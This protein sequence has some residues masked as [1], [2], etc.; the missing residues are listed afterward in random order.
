[1]LEKKKGYIY[2]QG[3]VKHLVYI[4]DLLVIFSF[5]NVLINHEDEYRDNVLLI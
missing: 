3:D 4:Y 1:M 2:I 5:E